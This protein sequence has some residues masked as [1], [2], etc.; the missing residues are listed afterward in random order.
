[1]LE[2]S[3]LER[4]ASAGPDGAGAR[5]SR[6]EDELVTT[7]LGEDEVLSAQCDGFF[8]TQRCVVQAPEERG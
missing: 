4:G 2:T 1:M 7:I 5:A 3:R 8:R 6:G